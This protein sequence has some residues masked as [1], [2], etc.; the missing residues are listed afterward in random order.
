MSAQ[1][2]PPHQ[3]VSRKWCAGLATVSLENMEHL[4]WRIHTSLFVGKYLKYYK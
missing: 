3:P 1:N 4:G 2:L